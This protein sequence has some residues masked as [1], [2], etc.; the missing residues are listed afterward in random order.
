MVAKIRKI[1]TLL[2]PRLRLCWLGLI[3]LSV[4]AAVLETIGAAAVF[5]L[6]KIMD[7]PQSISGMPAAAKLAAAF[8]LHDRA[9]IAVS[10]TILAAFFFVL[11]NVGLSCF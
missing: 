5:A 10:F 8:N 11:K 2:S 6:I 9:T 4:A 1:C 3:P 7:S